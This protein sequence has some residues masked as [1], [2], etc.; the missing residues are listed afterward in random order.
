MIDP[1]ALRPK[2]KKCLNALDATKP[3]VFG[4]H[5][6][7]ER[8]VSQ[9]LYV[10]GLHGSERA[11]VQVLADRI[12]FDEGGGTYL[13][14][15]NRGTG[16]TTELMRLAEMLRGSG[17]E[18]FYVDMAEYLNLTMAVEITDFLI[19]MLGGLSEKVEQRFGDD[20][21]RIG[22]FERVWNFLQ[23]EV[24]TDELGLEA[25]G[26]VK[27]SL[28]M[29]LRENPTFKQKLQESTRGHVAKL[30]QESRQFVESTVDYIRQ[31]SGDPAKKVV[32][33]LDSVERLRGVG[34]SEDVGKVFKSVETIFS[35]HADKLRLPPLY[36]VC[37]VPPYLTALAGNLAALYSGGR[38]YMLPSVHVYE[39]RP[40]DG[41]APKPSAIG[42]NA[43]VE[44]VGRRFPEWSQFFT[45]EQLLRL[46]ANSGGDLRDFF[47][48]VGL[49][50]TEALYQTSLP[51]P[52]SVL[53][54][55]ESALRNDMPLADDDRQKLSRVLNTHERPL[56]SLDKL[57]DFARLIEG[58]YLLNYRNGVDWYDVHPLLRDSVAR[59]G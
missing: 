22:F 52:D 25:G 37:T 56:E 29:S 41:E 31:Q 2:I 48:M 17:C 49:S 34:D 10:E 39:N 20:P 16:K 23:S 9:A 5:P 57:P 7:I 27:A 12:D 53:N 18:V 8:G 30:M 40:E 3:V 45:G 28:K 58:K 35:G 47:R 1:K 32:L 46:A 42:L 24:K 55:A 50:I 54:A 38:I 36:L 59:G 21:A 15:G 13:F 33:L 43:M 14:S 51:L 19:S 11:L 26:D 44:V 6:L 4:D